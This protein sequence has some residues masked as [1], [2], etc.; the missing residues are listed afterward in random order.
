MNWSERDFDPSKKHEV[1]N[2]LSWT[3]VKIVRAK[4]LSTVEHV[5]VA[6]TCAR[7]GHKGFW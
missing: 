2:V 1:T 6:G 5:R 3:G 4:D 7:Q